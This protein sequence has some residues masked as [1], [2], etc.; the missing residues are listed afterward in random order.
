MS[1]PTNAEWEKLKAHNALLL[2]NLT[3]TQERCNEL[4]KENRDY[5]VAIERLRGKLTRFR[6]ALSDMSTD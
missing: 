2:D 5:R 1:A 6:L 3:S 4:L